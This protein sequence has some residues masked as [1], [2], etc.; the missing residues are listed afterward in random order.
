MNSV[1]HVT[2]LDRQPWEDAVNSAFE[3]NRSPERVCCHVDC[4]IVRDDNR[5]STVIECDYCPTWVLDPVP[6]I[7][8]YF[9]DPDPLRI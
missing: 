9:L 3:K 4:T 7:P 5:R 1:I 8:H 6:M 2:Y